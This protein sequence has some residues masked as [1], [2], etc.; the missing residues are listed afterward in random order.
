VSIPPA[1]QSLCDHLA[2]TLSFWDVVDA[3]EG[4]QSG[5]G[6]RERKRARHHAAQYMIEN[7][8][9]WFVSRGTHTWAVTRQECV[10]KEEATL[11]ARVKHKKSGHFHHDLIKI[12]LLNR[13]H[14]LV[15]LAVLIFIPKKIAISFHINF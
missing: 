8:K 4:I 3:L 6:L 14:T 1:T 5:I 7:W 11:L 9:L 2:S 12:V 15:L 13:I 10:T